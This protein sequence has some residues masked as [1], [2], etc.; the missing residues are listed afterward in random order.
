MT[1]AALTTSALALGPH[2][3]TAEYHGDANYTTSISVTA[4]KV[5]INP[6]P[7]TTKPAI[8]E[9]PTAQTVTAPATAS[10]KAKASTPANCKAPTVQW[11]SEAPGSLTFSPIPGATLATYTTPATSTIE[12][13]TKFQ[14]IFT[15]GAGETSTSEVTL[16]INPPPCTTKPA[17]EEQP[18]AQTVTA[19]ATASFKAKAST[20]ANCK[21]PTVQWYSEAPGSLTFS[22]IPGATLATYTTPATSTIE[23]GTKFQAIFTNGAGETSTSEVT[24]TI[25]PPPCTTK[26]AIEE[27]PTAQTVTAPATASFKAKAST[28][29]N[30]KAPTVQWYSEAPGSLTFSPIPGAT[31]ATYTTPA[32]STIESGTK[33]QAIFTNGAGE[34]STSEVTLT[35]NP[36]PCTTKP[37]IEEQPTAQTVT[38]PATA[39]FKAKASTPAN[40]KAP[41]VQWYSEA[42]GSL[43][44][45]PIPGATLATYTTPATST[46]ESG[47]K[48][49][50]IFTNGAGETSTSEVTLTINPPPCTTKP[51]IEEQ[52]TA[53]T[54]TAPAT[55]SFKAKASTPANCKAPTV[56]WYSEAPGSLTFSPIPGATLATYTTPATSTIES[57]TKF[58]AIFTNGAGETSTSEVTLTI[59]PPP[60]TTKPAIEEQP[61]AQTVTAPATAS[62]KAKAS[63]P[64]NCKAPTV[65]WYSEA[66]GSLTFS[67]IPGA[68]LATYT[69]PATST[70]ESGTKFQAIFTNGAG[71]TSTSEVTLTINPLARSVVT[72]A[73]TSGGTATAKFGV[74]GE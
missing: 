41:T 68:T 2:E 70:I 60:C 27:Q 40:C 29:A 18:T 4:A 55:A 25:N 66:P 53:Q 67:P 11:Y 12:S 34:T 63:T 62:F 32:T 3:I 24:L 69:T 43:T 37:A 22:P 54:V 65:Q 38:A 9:Q 13:G 15:N 19:P 28:P 64:A 23:S 14:A 17:I 57:G 31:L 46:I 26:P 72:G 73:S 35:I 74:L 56:Q 45:S 47:T 52:P 20:P 50:A 71:E 5:T 39:S 8:E 7:C 58:Q 36:P 6:P 59:N 61:T 48:F 30:C 16:T 42:P 49:Q 21:A 44:F 1:T 51:A 10:F 33:F